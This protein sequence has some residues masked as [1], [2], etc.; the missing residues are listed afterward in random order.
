MESNNK[1][2]TKRFATFIKKFLRHKGA[3]FGNIIIFL[4]IFTALFAPI[5]S[6]YEYDE[7]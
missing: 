4:F 1:K 5:L 7:H 2:K 6:S 3:V